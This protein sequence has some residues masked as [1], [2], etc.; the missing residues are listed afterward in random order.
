MKYIVVR[1]DFPMPP[2]FGEW[3]NP[4]I[5]EYPEDWDMAL[6]ILLENGFTYNDNGHPGDRTYWIWYC[7]LRP[8]E[9]TPMKLVGGPNSGSPGS[10]RYAS[11]DGSVRGIYVMSPASAAVSV[12]FVARHC[13]KWNLFFTGEE[14]EGQAEPNVLFHH[15][16]VSDFD[17]IINT[18]WYN[19]NHDIFYLCGS[20]SSRN[21]SYLYYTY[22]SE[23]DFEGGDNDP[24]LV[25]EGLDK[26]LYAVAFFKVKDFDLVAYNVGEDPESYIPASTHYT[27]NQPEDIIDV[28]IE[29][30]HK[31]GVYYEYLVEG[32]DYELVDDDLHI[33]KLITL[34]PGDALEVN[35]A[36][37]TY[38][39]LLDIDSYR[40]LVWLVDWKLF[41]L[42]GQMGNYGRDYYDLFKPGHEGWVQGVGYGAGA[43]NLPWTFGNI[44]ETGIPTGGSMKWQN[45]GDVVTLNPIKATWVYEAEI[46]NR[47][48]DVG[49]IT[50]H[51]ITGEEMPWA[52]LKVE[53]SP[54]TAPG[55]DGMKV[56]ITIRDDMTWQDG[57]PI[58]ANDIKWNY[59]FIARVCPDL[60]KPLPELQPIWEYY[61]ESIVVSPY[62]IDVY[63]NTTGHWKTLDF[64]AVA[65]Q[66]PEVIWSDPQN[67]ANGL[68]NYTDLVG[69][70]PWD[71][72]YE[73][74]VGTP[75]PNGLGDCLSALM[76]AGPFYLNLCE[77]GWN[78]VDLAVL[79]KYEGYWKR[80]ASPADNDL[81]MDVDEDDLWFF[82]GAFITYWKTG[83]CD[84]LCDFEVDG[85]IDED[86]LWYFCARFID[87]YRCG[88]HGTYVP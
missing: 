88:L 22:H 42:V 58:T 80:L 34:Y 74:W 14:V 36:E 17:L 20:F 37:G 81:D 27:V 78:E 87:F 15:D 55:V 8:G 85:D 69:F 18:V 66:F 60:G 1:N 6:D 64:L 84:F 77:G 41:Y 48:Y 21:P 13:K 39:R 65:L 26:M 53:E 25:N 52:A 70:Q 2:G 28:K 32:V 72:T 71:W 47:I 24:G 7:P 46:L 38:L 35:Y 10:D 33:L 82:C 40:D 11:A 63:I 19:R 49:L 62:V 12:E 16:P 43:Y 54:Y 73:A 59:D 57:N 44:H 56:R 68:L 51:P 67:L 86:D 23:L 5:L 30:C 75:P 29:R 83:Y 4:Y 45:E 31:T 79:S 9:T 61:L 50:R 3:R 76:G